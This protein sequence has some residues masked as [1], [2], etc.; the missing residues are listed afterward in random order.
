MDEVLF[1]KFRQHSDLRTQLL[2]TYPSELVYESR[3]PFWGGDGAGAGAGRN[4]LGKSLMRVCEWLRS[5]GD[6]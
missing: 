1:L 4:E 3:N 6:M 5:V 2:N